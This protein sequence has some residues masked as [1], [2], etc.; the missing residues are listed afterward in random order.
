M[1]V[2]FLDFYRGL[3]WWWLRTTNLYFHRKSLWSML[4]HML[5]RKEGDFSDDEHRRKAVD[6]IGV[7]CSNV[8]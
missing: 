8:M 6:E 3:G 4:L 1:M 7:I 5:N 2:T